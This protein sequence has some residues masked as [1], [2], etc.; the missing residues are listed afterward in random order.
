MMALEK[1]VYAHLGDI[2]YVFCNMLGSVSNEN[3][4]SSLN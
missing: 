4:F 1:D 3:F 2:R